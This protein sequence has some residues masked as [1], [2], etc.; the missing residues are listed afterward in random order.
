MKQRPRVLEGLTLFLCAITASLPLQIMILYGHGPFE[1]GAVLA[2]LAPLNWLILFLAPF[3]AWTVFRGSAW[4]RL[5]VPLFAAL[6]VYNNWLVAMAGTDFSPITTGLATG[7]VL[8]A[9]T[10]LLRPEVRKMV[11][12]PEIRWWLISKRW[13]VAMP[14]RLKILEETRTQ[15]F[16]LSTFD[17]SE[18]GA[19]LAGSF[20]TLKPGTTCWVCLPLPG[21]IYIQCRGQVVRIAESRG[22]YP[23]GTGIQ[24]TGMSRT[25]QK[26]LVSWLKNSE[27]R[28][29]A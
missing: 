25:D 14:V 12:N 18:G 6:L 19:F 24:F 17:V 26:K 28:A 29:A 5:S 2:K 20:K 9:F 1:I 7:V 11:L 13:R 22:S 23:A 21:M 15:E 10:Q 3:T 4:M 27:N 8:L 16:N